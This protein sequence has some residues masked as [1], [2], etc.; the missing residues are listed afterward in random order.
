METL[1]K[2]FFG[3]AK[4]CDQHDCAREAMSLLQAFLET[5]PEPP[6]QSSSGQMVENAWLGLS[7]LAR[8]SPVPVGGEVA[9]LQAGVG[10][11][12]GAACPWSSRLWTNL[13]A[14]L[15]SAP[16]TAPA[17]ATFAALATAVRLEKEEESSWAAARIG[18]PAARVARRFKEGQERD[19]EAGGGSGYN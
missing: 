1:E 18:P 3:N 16:A 12:P 10:L 7:R 19:M 14:A 2:S 17:A 11:H 9:V 6:T 15:R 5:V 13:G 4:D 8:A